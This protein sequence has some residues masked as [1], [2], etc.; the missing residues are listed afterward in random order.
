VR[1]VKLSVLL[2]V[3]LGLLWYSPE[4]G[5]ILAP[6]LLVGVLFT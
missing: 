4:Y 5:V 6:V 1:I 3:M 2:G